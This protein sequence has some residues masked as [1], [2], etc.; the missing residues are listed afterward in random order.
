MRQLA[1]VAQRVVIGQQIV[2]FRLGQRPAV[3][4]RGELQESIADGCGSA[5][6]ASA[7][8]DAAWR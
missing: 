7:R 5:P 4:A 3:G 1:L 8:S 2:A 6:G